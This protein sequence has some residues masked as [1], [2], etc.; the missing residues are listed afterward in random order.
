MY[1]LV[2]VSHVGK[3]EAQESWHRYVGSQGGTRWE[4]GWQEVLDV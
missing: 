1:I 2:A 4:F 3:Y